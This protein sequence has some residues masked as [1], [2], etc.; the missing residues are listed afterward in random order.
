MST[1][2]PK[3]PETI[4]DAIIRR[5]PEL[6]KLYS[7]QSLECRFKIFTERLLLAGRMENHFSE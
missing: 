5:E 7:R 6:A 3:P 1:T 4:V 2:E